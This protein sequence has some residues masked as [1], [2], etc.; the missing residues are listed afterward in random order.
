VKGLRRRVLLAVFL[1]RLPSVILAI[2]H[3]KFPLPQ[4]P[5]SA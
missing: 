5:A 3:F 2:R 1:L 4:R